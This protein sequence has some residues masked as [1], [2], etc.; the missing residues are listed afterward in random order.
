MGR[1]SG[2]F[3]VNAGDGAA[4]WSEEL[5]RS[6]GQRSGRSQISEVAGWFL[7]RADHGRWRAFEVHSGF[8]QLWSRACPGRAEA[9]RKIR[10]QSGIVGR[11]LILVAAEIDPGIFKRSGGEV[12][13]LPW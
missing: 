10:G 9:H 7:A 13:F 4:I 6:G 3:A 12:R 11:R 5:A 8:I 1:R 2:S